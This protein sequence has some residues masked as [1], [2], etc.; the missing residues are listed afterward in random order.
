MID[1]SGFFRSTCALIMITLCLHFYN[2]VLL[3]CTEIICS[4][5]KSFRFNN[6]ELI[7]PKIN[8]EN[9]FPK[10]KCPYHGPDWRCD[11]YR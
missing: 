11:L 5:M 8:G 3:F 10:K 4:Y 6:F 9:S 1:D 2:I 7:V